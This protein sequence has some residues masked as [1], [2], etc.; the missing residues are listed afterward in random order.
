MLDGMRLAALGAALGVAG[1]FALSRVL[2]TLLYG[3][4]ATDLRTF[5]AVPIALCLVALAA[6][7]FP[8][9]RATRV[10]AIAAIRG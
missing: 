4:G 1:A 9:R 6:S 10:D 3:V 7:Y 5:V 8:A 2:S